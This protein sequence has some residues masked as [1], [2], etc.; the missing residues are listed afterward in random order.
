MARFTAEVDEDG[1]MHTE[2]DMDIVLI[3]GM[4][5]ALLLE[6]NAEELRMLLVAYNNMCKKRDKVND[7]LFTKDVVD[8]VEEDAIIR[9]EK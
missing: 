1:I 4:V 5:I 8:M 9:S 3:S 2:T 7:M 6:M